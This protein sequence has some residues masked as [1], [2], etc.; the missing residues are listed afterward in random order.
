M[1]I[2]LLA[3]HPF[4][5][6]R[7]TPIDVLLVLRVLAERKNTTV[8]LLVYNEGVNVDLTNL[9]IYR[10]PNLSFLK[11][12]NPGFSFKKLICDFFMFFKAWKLVYQKKYDLI[13]AGEESVFFAMFFNY[14]YKIPYVYDIDSSIAQQIVEKTPGL[15]AFANIFN[16]IEGAAIRKS[17][18]NL[19]V[20]NA[21]AELCEKN[22]SQ[23]T[24]TIHD[25]SQIKKPD[26]PT[27]GCLKLELVIDKQILLYICNLEHY[28]GLDLLLES[29][30]LACEDTNKIDLVIIGG[31]SIDIDF[32][33]EKS[34]KLKI[35]KQTHFLGPKPFE[36][37]ADYLNSADIL[38]C[39][40]IKGV[41]TPMKIF[42]YL[43]S[44]KPLLATDLYTHNQILTNNE[45]YLAP[46]DP[47]GFAEGIVAL[48]E[49]IELQK[50]FGRNGKNF[51]EKNHTF[52]AHQKRLN[53]VYDWIE[54]QI[55]L[56]SSVG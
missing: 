52:A 25:I 10:T 47:N 21:L 1:N 7:G 53:G 16:K 54:D 37:L 45:A 20:C 30:K 46:A 6:E 29:F 8:D 48:A 41:N 27:N 23:K 42:P 31:N 14:F 35:D 12:I 32:Y 17:L 38:T 13:H 33:K 15:S 18:A 36:K 19:P 34:R 43:H 22:G 5:Q 4:Y 26:H 2:L 24:V 51:V 49:N 39:P 3:P 56:G 11:N 50:R 28:Q 55:S 44:G 9:T 40:R